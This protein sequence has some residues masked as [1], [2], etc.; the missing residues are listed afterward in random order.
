MPFY[1]PNPGPRQ[2]Y[3]YS[4]SFGRPSNPGPF[5]PYSGSPRP[6]PR[7]GYQ[8]FG[9]SYQN[10]GL[11]A[12]SRNPVSPQ[13]QKSPFTWGNLNQAM[14]HAGNVSSGLSSIRQ[15]GS[16]FNILR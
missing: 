13:G 2:F 1:P 5:Q 3:P 14:I 8:G 16:L 4:R 11:F 15:M 12:Q 7:Q 10:Q 9:P 6:Y